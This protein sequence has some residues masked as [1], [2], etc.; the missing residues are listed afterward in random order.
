MFDRRQ[1]HTRMNALK[2]KL[3]EQFQQLHVFEMAAVKDS[4]LLLGLYT[5]IWA[6]ASKLFSNFIFDLQSIVARKFPTNFVFP[7]F[8]YL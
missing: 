1:P 7:V 3:S 2:L 6:L 4:G 5:I 8:L